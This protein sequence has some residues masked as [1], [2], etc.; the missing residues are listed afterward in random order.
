MFRVPKTSLLNIFAFCDNATLRIIDSIQTN[1]KYNNVY[2]WF[3]KYLNV[4][5]SL[6]FGSFDKLIYFWRNKNVD[7]FCINQ[8]ITIYAT[9]CCLNFLDNSKTSKCITIN[10]CKHKYDKFLSYREPFNYFVY[11]ELFRFSLFCTDDVLRKFNKIFNSSYI[12]NKYNVYISQPLTTHD[13]R[14]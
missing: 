1:N 11:S 2:K 6:F 8:T 3:E 9:Y 12:V 13:I 14:I 4:K 5:F 7:I 10:I